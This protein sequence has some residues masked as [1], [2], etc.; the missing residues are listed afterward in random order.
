MYN[1][2][3]YIICIFM[4]QRHMQ[5]LACCPVQHFSTKLAEEVRICC[6]QAGRRPAA[7]PAHGSVPGF[8]GLF[9]S[10]IRGGS[11]QVCNTKLPDAAMGHTD[12][13]F[14]LMHVVCCFDFSQLRLC[15][16]VEMFGASKGTCQ[17]SEAG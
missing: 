10:P 6:W 8:Q 5:S 17:S 2:Y 15:T 3:I 1:L 11:R 7:N 14:V 9:C 4:M 13:C 16:K 12:I